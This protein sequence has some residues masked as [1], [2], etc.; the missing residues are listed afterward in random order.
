MT[1][2]VSGKS[3]GHLYDEFQEKERYLRANGYK[4]SNCWSHELATLCDRDKTTFSERKK[5]Y[6]KL[7]NYGAISLRDAFFGGRTNNIS[8]LHDCASDEQ[9]KYFDFTSLYPYVLKNNPFPYGHPRVI[10]R[11]FDITLQSYFGFVKCIVLPPKDLF[12]PVL[13]MKSDGKLVFHLCT[14]CFETHLQDKC[15]HTD[16][17]RAII[18]TWPTVE[19]TLAMEKGYKIIDIIEV[20]DYSRPKKN[21]FET[22]VNLWLKIKQENS[23]PPDWVKNDEDMEKYIQLY[24]EKE[25]IELDRESITRNEGKRSIAKTKL[26]SLWGKFA[27]RKNLTKTSLITDFAEYWGLLND[28]K[29]QVQSEY[30]ATEDTVLLQYKYASDDDDEDFAVRNIAVAAFVTSYARVKLYRLIDQIESV[31][32]GRVLYFDTDS[33]IFVEKDC[34]PKIETG[35][36]LGELT[37]ELSAYGE[38]AVCKRFVSL[39]PKNYGYEIHLPS[40]ETKVT[41]KTKGIRLSTQALELINFEKMLEMANQYAQGRISDLR[42]PQFRI[43]TTT[44]SHIVYSETIEKIY[45][46]VSDKRRL[47]GVST[48]PYGYCS[49]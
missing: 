2:A 49:R 46:V 32:Q 13:P 30:N 20:Y 1:N 45:R 31:R 17:E 47:D 18:G 26:N 29:I 4:V 27:L 28:E 43:R 38:G 41:I 37:D 24:K 42:V 5:Y 16:N 34:D 14:K 40:G 8:F 22:Y 48:L 44:A 35:D 25:G 7:Q 39:G 9:I 33:V 3:M 11:D 21:V 15:Q 23:G 12:I 10:R 19:L 6:K 36:F